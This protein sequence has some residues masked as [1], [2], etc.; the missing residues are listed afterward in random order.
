MTANASDRVG[1]VLLSGLF[2]FPAL[3]SHHYVQ[4]LI[5]VD[6]FASAR[7][8]PRMNDRILRLLVAKRYSKNILLYDQKVYDRFSIEM[9]PLVSRLDYP[10]DSQPDTVH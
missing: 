4:C 8:A 2:W 3:A 10:F 5:P 7:L 1:G 9:H 6:R